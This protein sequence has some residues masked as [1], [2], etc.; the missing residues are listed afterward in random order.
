MSQCG[1]AAPKMLNSEILSFMET[2]VLSS[3]H[4]LPS[5]GPVKSESTR[6]YSIILVRPHNLSRW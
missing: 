4:T 1:D 5:Q 3:K 2:L 6:V